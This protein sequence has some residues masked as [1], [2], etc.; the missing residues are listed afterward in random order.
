MGALK[1]RPPN[2]RAAGIARACGLDVESAFLG[3]CFI[4]RVTIEPAPARQTPFKL[5]ELEACGATGWLAAAPSENHMYDLA[6]KEFEAAAI[7]KRPGAASH[8]P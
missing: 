5:A 7:A 4:G 8:K 3:D 6:M 1:R 2:T